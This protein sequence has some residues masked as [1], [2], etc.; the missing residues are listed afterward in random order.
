MYF[1]DLLKHKS[2][3]AESTKV[4]LVSQPADTS[5]LVVTTE[6]DNALA[7]CKAKVERIAKECR[8]QNC[9]FR[10][11]PSSSFG[12]DL[13]LMFYQGTLNLI[14]K[15]TGKRA[16]LSHAQTVHIN[17]SFLLFS[18]CLNGLLPFSGTD[19]PSDVLR[20]TQ[21]WDKPKFVDGE[22]SNDIVQGQ[23]GNCWF[24]SAL[25]TMT[26]SKGLVEKFCVAVSSQ[27]FSLGPLKPAVVRRGGWHLWVHFLQ[28]YI[29][30]LLCAPG[31]H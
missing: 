29:L 10:Y 17:F 13:A 4:G 3:T 30:C 24:L 8:E 5:G 25:S 7:E 14:W 27:T 20:C 26:T 22:D 28:G 6:L 15:A 18:K 23:L 12:F 31:T 11:T 9:K 16:Y 19:F 21:I 2:P 1:L